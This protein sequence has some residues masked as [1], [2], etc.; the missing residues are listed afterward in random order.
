MLNIKSYISFNLDSLPLVQDFYRILGKG[1]CVK[2]TYAGGCKQVRIHGPPYTYRGQILSDCWNMVQNEEP[3]HDLDIN[4]TKGDTPLLKSNW[5]H[6]HIIKL[7]KIIITFLTYTALLQSGPRYLA[8]KL[9]LWPPSATRSSSLATLHA[10]L[11]KLKTGNVVFH[12]LLQHHTS[13]APTHPVL[14]VSQ[15][16]STLTTYNLIQ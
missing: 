9:H 6:Y 3:Q 14:S 12:V 11:V 4:A 15:P 2:R 7:L 8:D 10:P 1:Y 13:G 16:I 5:E